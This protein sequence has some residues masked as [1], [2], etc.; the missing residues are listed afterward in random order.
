[1]L[2]ITVIG[3][4][5]SIRTRPEVGT[6][7]G[8]YSKVLINSLLKENIECQVTNM[9]Y[10]GRI[11][12]EVEYTL[13]KYIQTLPDIVIVNLGSVDVATREI[14]RWFYNRMQLEVGGLRAIIYRFIYRFLIGKWKT[15]FVK[16]RGYKSWVSPGQFMDSLDVILKGIK[17]DSNA[18]LI[19]MG[20]NAGNERIE[21][22]LPRTLQR[23][24][25]L[26]DLLRAYI[27]KNDIEHLD[28]SSLNCEIDYPDGIHY[29]SEGHEKI[30]KMLF[31][32]I[33]ST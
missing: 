17:K 32:K 21:K 8:C 12:Y 24:Q 20:V 3:N 2:R 11:I 22:V 26:N 6:N 15:S 14:P 19:V 28:V 25:H 7:D 18:K 33:I 31:E 9:G 5:V 10:S 29:S 4:S 30:G 13:D 1:M 23:Y 16:L 27:D